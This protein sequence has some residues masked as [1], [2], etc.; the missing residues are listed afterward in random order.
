MTKP[1]FK[2]YA[3]STASENHFPHNSLVKFSHYLPSQITL[4]SN[5]KWLVAVA[6][7]GLHLNINTVESETSQVS[8]FWVKSFKHIDSIHAS[9]RRTYTNSFVG[10]T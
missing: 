4:D 1:S 2:I 8:L 10:K 9:S 6:G 7:I 3:V 5:K